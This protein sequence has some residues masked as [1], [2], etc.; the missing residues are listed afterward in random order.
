MESLPQRSW[1]VP[2]QALAAVKH[3][4]PNFDEMEIADGD[5][6]KPLAIQDYIQN[7]D[8][9]SLLK[10]D[11]LVATSAELE[12]NELSNPEVYVAYTVL[13]FKSIMFWYESADNFTFFKAYNIAAGHDD[14]VFTVN[15]DGTTLY[16]NLG[17]CP[18]D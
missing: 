18:G 12:I 9:F 2:D 7:K 11:P 5:P 8:C 16:F 10:F 3:Q 15:H 14:V 13:L 4:I 6:G 17:D 1:S